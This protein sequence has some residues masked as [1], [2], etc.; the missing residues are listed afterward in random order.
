[1]SRFNLLTFLFCA[2]SIMGKAQT[3]QSLFD[4]GKE[5]KKSG[6]CFE[7]IGKFNQSL[8]LDPA[9]TD[10]LYEKGWCQ[11]ELKQYDQ[12]LKTLRDVRKVWPNVARVHFELGYVFE[13]TGYTDS[14]VK[15][16]EACLQIN[17]SYSLVYKQFGNMAYDKQDYK[18]ALSQF[19]KY[20]ELTKT[21]IKDYSFWYRKGYTEN[22][23][24]DFAAA[25]QSLMRSLSLKPDFAKTYLELGY[26]NDKLNI[27]DSAI[28]YF[29]KAVNLEPDNHVGYNGIAAVYRDRYKNI[30]TAMEWY[31]K[32]LKLK[33]TERKA[34]FGMGYCLN[35][36]SKFSEAI[37]YLKQAIASEPSYSAAFT[38]IGYSYYK[39]NQDDLAE[40]H[41]KKA[42]EM[43]PSGVSQH[44]YAALLYLRKKDKQKAL[45]MADALQR[46]GSRYAT[47]IRERANQLP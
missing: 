36:Q 19:V 44:Y 16:Y 11:V 6:K 31:Q 43:N 1:M 15:S 8:S 32:T 18:T 40:Q 24:E 46:M 45:N 30:P 10:A 20:I 7:A 29:Q 4:E 5:L 35:T 21:E 13:K 26:T 28:F 47:E 17:P 38:E 9:L 41:L 27:Y 2:I 34:N 12:A 14:A 23:T 37:T 3:A 22:N 25:K 33:P 42:I 39:T